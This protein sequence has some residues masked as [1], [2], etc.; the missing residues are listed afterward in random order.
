MHQCTK[1]DA[2]V[3][4]ERSGLGFVLPLQLKAASPEGGVEKHAV[5][6]LFMYKRLHGSS[7]RRKESLR[8]LSGN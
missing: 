1:L 2:A 4:S 5:K 7:C 3:V 6:A 8:L